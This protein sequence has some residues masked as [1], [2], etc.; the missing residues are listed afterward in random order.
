MTKRSRYAAV[1]AALV[2]VLTGCNGSG[3]SDDDGKDAGGQPAEPTSAPPEPTTASPTS[4]STNGVVLRMTQ[5]TTTGAVTALQ[6][7][8]YKCITDVA[9][10]I[11]KS[12]PVEVWLLTGDHKRFPVASV[13]SNG[14]VAA[15]RQAVG[16]RL[17]QVLRTLH[18]NEA[19][20][21]DQWYD[22]QSGSTTADDTI[23]D[24]KVALSAEEG[25][26]SPGV[27]LTLNDRKCKQHCQAE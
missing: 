15:A 10:M 5:L 20:Q 9:Y 24:W 22:D 2:L 6:R 26:D 21:I 12:G 17:P 7:T 16:D 25:S 27:H 18:V 23:G 19:T 8:G 13:H 3:G 11:C 14:A 1:V 4:H